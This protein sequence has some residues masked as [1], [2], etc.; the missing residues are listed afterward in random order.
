MKYKDKKTGAVV[1]TDSILSGD[2]E[3]IPE[4]Q[5]TKKKATKTAKE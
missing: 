5:E 3:L 4:K 2:W 1:I